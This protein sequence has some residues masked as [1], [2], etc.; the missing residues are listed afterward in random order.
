ML[1]TP[2]MKRERIEQGD[3]MGEA[4][5][6]PETPMADLIPLL[7]TKCRKG[8]PYEQ[9]MFL[10]LNHLQKLFGTKNIFHTLPL[11]IH[12]LLLF[13]YYLKMFDWE[14]PLWRSRNK[15]N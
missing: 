10:N 5:L 4:R 13:Y 7:D 9:V 12:F 3:K 2:N 15:S 8:Q 11:N 14:F 1:F 6:Y